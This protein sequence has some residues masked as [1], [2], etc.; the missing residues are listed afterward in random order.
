M[1]K[2]WALIMLGLLL[3]SCSDDE[4]NTGNDI[5]EK[6][7]TEQDDG[8]DNTGESLESIIIGD[9]YA[10]CY[11]KENDSKTQLSI[12]FKED[13]QGELKYN[14]DASYPLTYTIE[15]DEVRCLYHNAA[16]E[17]L[18]LMLELRNGMLY[19]TTDGVKQ[20]ILSQD[21]NC[22]Y[23]NTDGKFIEDYYITLRKLW[24]ND[25]G[26]NILD[27]RDNDI[28]V[29]QLTAPHAL[30]YNYFCMG[31]LECEYPRNIFFINK[32]IGS[33][34]WKI[35]ELTDDKLVITG[36]GTKVTDTYR[37][38]Q[39]SDIPSTKNIKDVLVSPEKWENS[40][41]SLEVGLTY[42]FYFEEDGTFRLIRSKYYTVNGTYKVNGNT[43]EL[44]CT[45]VEFSNDRKDEE[46]I[47]CFVNGQPCKINCTVTVTSLGYAT[48]EIPEV[49]KALRFE[50]IFDAQWNAG[51]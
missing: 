35:D 25:N 38:G 47:D 8:N 14:S 50:A 45:H 23:T 27:M 37:L 19:P 49:W 32:E 22:L 34:G 20:F 41:Y 5:N 15:A 24:I 11:D 42:W 9:W 28:K 29:I 26:M 39:E 13:G 46:K 40:P 17:T 44:D 4:P 30:T 1:Y 48:I 3:C 7:D 33:M 6:P 12:T 10:K 18:N 2:F 36:I 21:Y 16:D 51:Q 43:L 31:G